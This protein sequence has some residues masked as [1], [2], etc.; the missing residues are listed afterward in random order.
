MESILGNTRR[1][2]ISFYRGGRIDIT[3]SIARQLDIHNG[4]VID[5]VKHEDEFYLYVRARHTDI[6]GK[7]EAQCF[8]TKRNSRNFR[9]H[10]SRLCAAILAQC[11]SEDKAQL[12]AGQIVDLQ[13]FGTAISLI[14]NNNLSR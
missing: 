14:T 1:P 3:S 8:S 13:G 6:I 7:N 9:A 4:D 2:D 10:S 12:P 11:H 5:I